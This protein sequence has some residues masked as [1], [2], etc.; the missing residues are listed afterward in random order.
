MRCLQRNMRRI[1]YAN[2]VGAEYATKEDA[3][4]VVIYDGEPRVVY[5]APVELLANVSP[6]SGNATQDVFGLSLQYDRV[7]VVDDP[8][9]PIDEASVLWI[10]TVPREGVPHDYVVRRVARGLSSA[11]IAVSRVNRNEV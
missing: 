9:T 11:A 3:D 8:N 1:Y 5:S 4:G 10:D 6:A 7:V 2:Y